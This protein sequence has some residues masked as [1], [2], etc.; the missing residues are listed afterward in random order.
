MYSN[1]ACYSF[2][3]ILISMFLINAG[4]A[5]AALSRDLDNVIAY[6]NPFEPKAGHS[7]ITFDNLTDSARIRI[8]TM[9]GEQIL[10]KNITTTN[11][12][13]AWD[14]KNNDGE[15]AAHGIYIYLIT[16]DKGQKKT[17]KLG[18]KR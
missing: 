3:L 16:N 8:Y 7:S 1:R 12:K 11:G 2:T 15:N 18:I 4:A 17:G 13:S 9:N 6:P 10:D 5:I 14:V